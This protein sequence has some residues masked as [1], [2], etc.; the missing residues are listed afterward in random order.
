MADAGTIYA[1]TDAVYLTDTTYDYDSELRE[2]TII[3]KLA[4][5]ADGLPEYVA[6]GQ[7]PGRL[8]SQFSLGEYED[9]LRVATHVS[10]WNLWNGGAAISVATAGSSDAAVSVDTAQSTS[11]EA[12]TG[13]YNAVYTLEVVGEDLSIIG[14]VENIAPGEDLYA[15]RFM[16]E[17]GFLVTYEIVDPLFTL[18]LSDPEQPTVVGE[19][20]V[21]GYSDYLHPF[22]D[23]FL[24]G[25]GRSTLASEWGSITNAIQLSLFD[26]SDLANPTVIDQIEVGG[27][28]SY[29][30]VS[31]THKAF[32]FMPDSGLLA[33]P[34]ALTGNDYNAAGGWIWSDWTELVICYQVD[35]TGFTERGRLPIMIYEDSGWT[36]WR[37]AAFI[38]DNVYALSPAGVS[39]APIT[40]F[41]SYRT[42][43][44]TPNAA[45]DPDL[46]IFL[47]G[48]VDDGGEDD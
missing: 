6:S 15:V 14:S 40:D 46:P 43:V 12:P 48:S 42:F 47:G 29:S 8:L 9:V 44:L 25:V 16:G 31:Y 38:D 7:V 5:D 33:I 11:S 17:R 28:G 36:A 35:E 2:H 26:I 30:D 32:T 39:A 23:N 45:D 1:S 34:A 20:E 18:D 24:I 21:P 4:F 13:P 37:R 22:G 19:L 10:N 41:E 27:Y 3:H